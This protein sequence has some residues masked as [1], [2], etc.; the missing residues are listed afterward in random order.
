[1]VFLMFAVIVIIVSLIAVKHL[2]F[3]DKVIIEESEVGP[4]MMIAENFVGPF[5]N[6][7]PVMKKIYDS[8]TEDGIENTVGFGIYYDNPKETTPE[9]LRSIVGSVL[10]KESE[11]EIDSL[12]EK[13]KIIQYPKSISV[14]AKIPLRSKLSYMIGPM[15]VYPK[16][17]KYIEEKGK[18]ICPAL[19]LYDME[20]KTISYIF[21]TELEAEHFDRFLND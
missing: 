8:L 6:T 12:R 20:N 7:A 11:F 21:S 18:D 1:M 5:Q 2:G 17:G 19:E 16:L 4:F 10:S 13:Y 3:F 14:S 15:R 9:K